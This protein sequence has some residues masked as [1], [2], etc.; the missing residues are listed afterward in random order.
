MNVNEKILLDGTPLIVCTIFLRNQIWQLVNRQI[1]MSSSASHSGTLLYYW[2]LNRHAIEKSNIAITS[3]GCCCSGKLPVDKNLCKT[4]R[5]KIYIFV[6]E[7]R[8][9]NIQNLKQNKF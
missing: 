3:L 7:S 1:V 6:D 5:C 4:Y 8:E 2:L 9:K